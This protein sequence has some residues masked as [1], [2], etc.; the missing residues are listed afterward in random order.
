MQ[1]L[2]GWSAK[3]N[4]LFSA[5]SSRLIS[6]LDAPFFWRSA[7]NARTSAVVIVDMRRPR[8]NGFRDAA[9]LIEGL[10]PYHAGDRRDSHWLGRP[11]K[12]QQ[13]RQ[14]SGIG[15]PCRESQAQ[16][17]HDPAPR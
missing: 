8:K 17:P 10:Q 11:E 1:Q 9:A 16:Y 3:L 7:T 2:P 6:P 15:T 12:T 5:V 14:A 4:I 13:Y